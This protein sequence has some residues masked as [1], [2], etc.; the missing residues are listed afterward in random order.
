MPYPEEKGSFLLRQ[1]FCYSN[2]F[3]ENYLC[4]HK[5]ENLSKF[6]TQAKKNNAVRQTIV[7]KSSRYF[8]M[9]KKC[10]TLASIEP[11]IKLHIWKKPLI[12]S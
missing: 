4:S 10:E 8:S 9:R 3:K 2:E 12:K 11:D 5:D 1:S 7:V 6:I